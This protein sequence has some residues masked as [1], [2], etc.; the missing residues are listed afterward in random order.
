M[1]TQRTGAEAIHALLIGVDGYV[2]PKA[3]TKPLYPPL[4]GC[5]ADVRQVEGYLAGTLG[6]PAVNIRTLTASR[7]GD[8]PPEPPERRPTYENLVREIRLLLDRARPGEQALIYYSG[9]GAQAK[10]FMPELKGKGGQDECLVPY[11]VERSHRLLRDVEVH[12]LLSELAA[13][14]LVLTLVLDCCHAAGVPRTTFRPR[15][16]RGRDDRESPEQSLVA[17]REE[18]A[19]RWRPTRDVPTPRQNVRSFKLA[20]TWVP[21]PTGYVLLAAC[22]PQELAGEVEIAPGEWGGVLTRF[23]LDELRHGGRELSWERLHDRL[24]ARVKTFRKG[25]TPLLEGEVERRVLGLDALPSVAGFPVRHAA[26]GWVLLGAGRAHALRDGARLAVFTSEANPSSPCDRANR[27]G[28]VR[29]TAPA[30]LTAE[31][32]VDELDDPARPPLPG[33]RALLLE[34]GT[35]GRQPVRL[36]PDGTERSG[37]AEALAAV[38]REIRCR[39]AGR[40]EL[41]TADATVADALEVGLTEHGGVLCFEIRD[42][43]GEPL[44]NQGPPLPVD[45]PASALAV[46]DRLVRIALFRGVASLAD[47]AFGT[48]LKGALKLRL[49]LLENGTGEPQPLKVRG[50]GAEAQVGDLLRF[51]VENRSTWDLNI[52]VLDLQPDFGVSRVWPP[53]RLFEPIGR[54]GGSRVVDLHVWLPDTIGQGDDVLRIVASTEPLDLSTITM[55]GFYDEEPKQRV[56]RSAPSDPA[57]RLAT[58]VGQKPRRLRSGAAP[59]GP[60]YWTFVDVTVRVTRREP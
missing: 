37:H 32:T 15:G 11:D 58:L 17:S 25:Q 14:G 36:E 3:G 44:A 10:T 46:V 55:P 53:N 23:L 40:L 45:R 31:A 4:G 26:D 20:S 39:G 21:E 9:H 52:A 34:L 12:F 5:V 59:T 57:A 16:G 18:L 49:E 33:D 27:I 24:V 48:P 35:A 7:G 47:D 2:Q 1:I 29:V 28:V 51:T 6:V 43:A 56:F 42:T 22:R 8:G 54:S 13:R 50:G 30:A 38:G 41:V 19:A 60:A